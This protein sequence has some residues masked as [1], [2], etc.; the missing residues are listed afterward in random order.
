MHNEPKFFFIYI[1]IKIFKILNSH[2]NSS[3]RRGVGYVLFKKFLKFMSQEFVKFRYFFF[4]EFMKNL[5]FATEFQKFEYIDFSEFFEA[6]SFYQ[7]LHKNIKFVKFKQ[8]SYYIVIENLK[9]RKFLKKT[10]SPK[11]G[12]RSTIHFLFF[13]GISDHQ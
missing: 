8:T 9:N 11:R 7:M 10:K 6:K 4:S 2:Q 3:K 12:K 5:K 1:I 13:I